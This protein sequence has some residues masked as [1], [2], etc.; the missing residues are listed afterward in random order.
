MPGTLWQDV[1]YALRMMRRSPVFT[2]VAVLSLAL[3]I[4]ANTAIFSL[5]HAVMLRMLPVRDP[6]QLVELLSEYPGEPR[7]SFFSLR[8]YQHYQDHNHVFSGLTGSSIS[9][10]KIR[11]AGDQREMAQGEFVTGSYFPVLGVKAAA[12]RLLGPEDDRAGAPDSA[13]VVVSWEYWKTRL[14]SAPGVL[15]KRIFIDDVPLTVVGVAPRGFFGLQV[16]V[17]PEVWVPV[18]MEPAIHHNAR[19]GQG[20]L[21]LMARLKP[22]VS[23]AQA[24]AEM[25]VLFPFT[26]DER[27]ATNKD[28]LIR[29]M[30]FELEPAGAGFSMLRDRFA[31]PLFALMAV[32]G[33]LL[34]IACTN[35]ASLL[36]AR[37][38]SRQREMGLRAAL[39]ASRFRLLR[40]VLTESLLLSV[41]GALCGVFLAYS[42]AEALVGVLTSGRMI[43]PRLEVPV[44]PNLLV[45]AF[46]GGIALLTGLLFG[47]A[48]AWSAFT[49][50]PAGSLRET[51][52]IGDT[53][54][55]RFFGR[56]LVVAQVAFS[57]VLVSAATLFG[58]YLSNLEHIDL[59]FRRDHVLLV[60]LDPTSSGYSA[61]QLS[62]LYQ[63][64]LGRLEAIPGVV[65]ATVGDTP[66][67]GAGASSFA[68]A[69]G[70]TEQPQD[71]RYV[72][73]RWVGPKYFETLGTPL[74]TGRDFRFQDQGGPRVAILNHAMA[75][76]FFGNRNPLGK[77][78]ALDRDWKGFGADKPYE[79]IG[80]VGDAKY[81]EIRE[82][83]P[84]TI[85][86]NAFREGDVPS[87]FVLRTN[88]EPEAVTGT[89]QRVAHDL[90]KTIPMARVTTLADQVDASIVPER[91]I[92]TLSGLFGV[93]GA[94]LTAIGI[95]GLLAYTFARRV[96]EI[97]IRMALGATRGDV[98]RMVLGDALTMVCAGLLIGAPIAFRGKSLAADLLEG[99]P[100]KGVAPVALA[101]AAMLAIAL[102]AAYV[103]AWRAARVDP[104]EALR[105]E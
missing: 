30:K 34:L 59:G 56:A 19:I 4:G 5:I 91:L 20:G 32:V 64:L 101:G 104:M 41:A 71:R 63:E 46:T 73:I 16:G 65:S 76:Y 70:F 84:R 7:G 28:P 67:S 93:L 6:G 99:L 26:I 2:A 9:E 18:A 39:G 77:H 66:I 90:L 33:L 96:N 79:I 47:L 98:I 42:G 95:Y 24:R 50:A 15:G 14:G 8:S 49:S 68:T 83:P 87:Q 1:R 48:P 21:R 13:V 100:A 29:Q 52:R 11:S 55:R 89:V 103:P 60:T 37:G 92:A 57:M 81:N 44:S 78:V 80:V 86:F 17:K 23:L 25:S 43:G 88:I 38:A 12:G 40:Q 36:L 27:A 54:F 61:G 22:G 74:L 10:F 82:A 97:G 85:Y 51:G 58:G 72:A 31:K 45:L 94:G 62:R 53:R 69:E 35:V 3:G 75:R 102:L 105:H